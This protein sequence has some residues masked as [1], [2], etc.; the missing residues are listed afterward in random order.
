MNL[1]VL[2]VGA[3]GGIQW[4]WNKFDKS[5]LSIILVEPDVVEANR[6]KKL[7]KNFKYEI[8]VLPIALWSK[9]SEINLNLTKSLGASSVFE[10]NTKFLEQFPEVDRFSITKKIKI[11]TDTI[12]SIINSGRIKM[13]DFAKIDVQGAELEIL[14]GGQFHFKSNLIGLELEVEFID[15]YKK[16]PFFSEIDS[17]IRNSLGLE[18]WDINKS[19]WKYKD[20]Y[21]IKGPAKGRLIFG[22]A[23]Y[24]R[25]LTNIDLWLKKS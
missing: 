9:K 6:L 22:D 14:K 2:D 10:P 17:Y 21:K 23:L 1:Q 13:I 5:K 20:G 15:M 25:P 3:R 11:K 7:Y 4:P 19:C 18:L 8:S 12:D 24:F 16:Q